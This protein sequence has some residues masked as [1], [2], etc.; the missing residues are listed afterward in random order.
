MALAQE[1]K[2][3]KA[4]NVDLHMRLAARAQNPQYPNES[5]VESKSSAN[6]DDAAR[7][8]KLAEEVRKFGK[9]HVILYTISLTN[10]AFGLEKPSFQFDDP[11]R[12]SNVDNIDL[13]ATAELYASI[14][15][16]FHD[17]LSTV[18][19]VADE[20]SILRTQAFKLPTYC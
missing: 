14:P 5:E 9:R 6:K 7:A 20:V 12:Y 4:D 16:K 17:Y 8:A 1:V 15:P 3:L 18:S 11:I 13:G 2:T 10:E 19:S